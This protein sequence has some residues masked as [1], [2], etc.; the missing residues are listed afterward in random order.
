MILVFKTNRGNG[1]DTYNIKLKIN[2]H[3]GKIQLFI[4]YFYIQL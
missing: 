1:K 4:I 2:S 3:Y